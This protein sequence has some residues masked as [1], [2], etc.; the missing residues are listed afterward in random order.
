MLRSWKRYVLVSGGLLGCA[1]GCME[2][3][4]QLT[5]YQ[6]T[7]QPAATTT[8]AAPEVT[9]LA[10]QDRNGERLVQMAE[11]THTLTARS[12]SV[13]DMLSLAYRSPERRGEILPRLS[14]LRIDSPDPL[15]TDLYD[16]RIYQAGAKWPQLRAT[17]QRLLK[18]TFGL[19]V[20]T[21]TRTG[22]VLVLQAPEKRVK[23]F[24]PA[25]ETSQAKVPIGER[26]AVHTLLSGDDLSL[27]ADQLEDWVRMPVLDETGVQSSYALRVYQHGTSDLG[28]KP[29]LEAICLSLEHQLA[30]NLRTARRPV[31]YLVVERVGAGS[32]TRAGEESR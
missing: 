19:T 31:E 32:A 20:R 29:D 26:H 14:S 4:T 27:L 13:A 24:Q 7:T 17:L 16:L 5:P 15:P 2:P 10:A 22:T 9:L 28:S 11:S 25:D 1:W 18:D 6:P 23:P 12:V 21:E 8:V 30:L 3:Q